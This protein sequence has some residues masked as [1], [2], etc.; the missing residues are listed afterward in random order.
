MSCRAVQR[1][2][3]GHLMLLCS[4]SGFEMESP[5]SVLRALN[6]R[7]ACSKTARGKAAEDAACPHVERA[8]EET[9]RV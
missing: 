4:G 6:I 3:V 1:K 5:G 8:K 7:G 9:L 2:H